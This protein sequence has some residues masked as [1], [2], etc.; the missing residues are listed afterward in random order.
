M[1]QAQVTP[2]DAVAT[3]HGKGGLL[4][5]LAQLRYCTPTTAPEQ[6]LRLLAQEH[7]LRACEIEFV[8]QERAAV[9]AAALR[10]PQAPE[11]FAAWLREVQARGPGQQDPLFPWLAE[12]ATR[13]EFRWF[14]HQRSPA[15]QVST[16]WWP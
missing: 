13:R 12:H 4:S 14:L 15:K 11:G 10:A 7:A 1:H 6:P 3:P 8:E 9:R 16:T 2:S 5:R